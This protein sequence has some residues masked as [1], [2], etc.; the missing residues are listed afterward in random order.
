VE[1]ENTVRSACIAIGSDWSMEGI[2]VIFKIIIGQFT[3]NKGMIDD[4]SSF[5]IVFRVWDCPFGGGIPTPEYQQGS[6]NILVMDICIFIKKSFKL[7]FGFY[8]NI[9][10]Q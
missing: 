7:G 5:N 6:F 10:Y 4:I 8:F 9:Y 1:G 2:S 3:N